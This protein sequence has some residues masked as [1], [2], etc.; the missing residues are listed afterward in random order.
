M[1]S[2]ISW[3]RASMEGE[4]GP[5]VKKERWNEEGKQSARVGDVTIMKRL[6]GEGV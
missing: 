1:W 5:M 4:W 6:H 2:S 3:G